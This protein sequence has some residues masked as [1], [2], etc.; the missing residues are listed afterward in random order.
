MWPTVLQTEYSGQ[1]HPRPLLSDLH[2]FKICCFGECKDKHQ[3]ISDK[4]QNYKMQ[5]F[6]RL[7]LKQTSHSVYSAEQ[8]IRHLFKE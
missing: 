4:Q 5:E 7:K 2:I 3:V 1:S 6:H 8:A